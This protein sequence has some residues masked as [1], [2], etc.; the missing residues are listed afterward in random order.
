MAYFESSSKT[1]LKKGQKDQVNIAGKLMV[2]KIP[3]RAAESI[4][5][6]TSQELITLD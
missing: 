3:V 2:A 6:S 1:H 4:G 5:Q